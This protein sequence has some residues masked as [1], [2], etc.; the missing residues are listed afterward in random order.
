MRYR[1]EALVFRSL[2]LLARAVPRRALLV[3]GGLAGALGYWIDGRHRRI[4]LDNLARVYGP[5]LDGHRARRIA[6]RCWRHFGRITFDALS[7][8]RLDAGA[9]GRLVHYEG[10]EHIRGAYAKG[11]GVLL[12]S[13]HFGHWEL[14]A[15]MQGFLG[16]PL[17]LVARPL[18]N[19]HLE[20]L[21]ARL[22]GLSGNRVIHKRNAVR[23]ML[24]ALRRREG[25]AIVL[26]QDARRDG[27][28]VPFL[29]RA[30]ST[31]PT[32]ALLA[33]RTG[34]AVVPTYS[35][36]R[37]DGSYTIV[38]EPEVEIAATGDLDA[39]VHRITAECTA[40]IEGWIKAHPEL[41][42]WMHRRWKTRPPEG[43]PPPGGSRG[44]GDGVPFHAVASREGTHGNP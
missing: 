13:A 40:R 30:A 39:D 10:L 15:L 35:V 29:G 11:K 6:R 21:L 23:E 33:V 44:P 41:W 42:L 32:L 38:Y 31:T 34:A 14:T 19:P 18:D 16:L 17:A 4:A 20:P 12:F 37:R 28:F 22:R 5:G 36:P 26:D 8:P 24:R 27:V 7:F 25:V 3:L 1:L 43:G 2:L 9:V